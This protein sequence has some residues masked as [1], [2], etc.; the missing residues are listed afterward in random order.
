MPLT[1]NVESATSVVFSPVPLFPE[2]ATDLVMT[3]DYITTVTVTTTIWDDIWIDC[4][5]DTV[6]A[7]CT[8]PAYWT[9]VGDGTYPTDSPAMA[10]GAAPAD[11]AT[12][13]A[14]APTG[15]SYEYRRVHKYMH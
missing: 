6:D 3:L 14:A 1:G 5:T 4:A 12:P 10:S 9:S 8:D 7:F 13:A 15:P 2:R 11:A